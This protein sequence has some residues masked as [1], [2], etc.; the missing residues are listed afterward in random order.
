LR[1]DFTFLHACCHSSLSWAAG[2]SGSGA[3]AGEADAEALKAL[4]LLQLAAASGSSD[5]AAYRNETALD[6]LR[7]RPDFRL[8]LMDLDMP[9]DP[10]AR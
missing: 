1:P 9:A 2:L 5:P 10:F 4:A 7:G 8:L 3:P 6:P